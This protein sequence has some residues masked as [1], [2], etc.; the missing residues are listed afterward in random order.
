MIKKFKFP[1]IH[2]GL[3]LLFSILSYLSES[4]AQNIDTPVFG[5]KSHLP[6]QTGKWVT[7]S[8]DNIIY[9]SEQ[10]LL[11]LS[12]DDLSVSFLSKINGL[13][14]SQ[15]DLIEYDQYNNQ[16]VII[17]NNS[18]IDLVTENEIYNIPDIKDNSNIIGS[19][20]IN[21][22]AI[23]NPEIM[24]I[25]T[26]FGMVEYR[27]KL[28]E[29]GSTIFTNLPIN[30][31]ANIGTKIYAATDDGLYYIDESLNP[32]IAD[33][34][35]WQLLGES[36]GLPILYEAK[37]I[38]NFDDQ[39]FFTDG[40]YIYF[41]M[42]N[43][44]F[45]LLYNEQNASYN[46]T[47]LSSG[48]KYLMAGLRA[49]QDSRILYWENNQRFEGSSSCIDRL[50][51]SIEDEK[52]QIWFADN[53][54]GFRY[55]EHP[56]GGCQRLSFNS[57]LTENG[58]N[59]AIHDG[60]VAVASGGVT[61]NFGDLF[62]RDGIYLLSDNDWL[63][64]NESFYKPM[65][66]NDFLNQYKVDF[67]P[68]GD[69]L[70][71]G[72]FWNG[73]MEYN[74]GDQSAVVYNQNNS[75][76]QGA[77]G[78]G[79]A[80]ISDMQFDEGGNLWITNFNAPRPLVVKDSD[81]NWQ[82]FATNSDRRVGDLTIDDFNNI[83]ITTFGTSGGLFVFNPGQDLSSAGDD[84]RRSINLNNS[85]ISS[86]IIYTVAADLDGSVWV[87]TAEGVVLFECG[88]NV[89]N[90]NECRGLRP[91]VVVDSIVAFL[92]ETEE[93]RCIAFDGADRKWFGTRNGI[94]VQ[95]PSGDEEVA[96]FTTDNSPLFDNEI[97][98]MAFDPKNGFMYISSNKGLQ[99]IRTETTEGGT[100][101]QNSVYAFPNPVTPD[102][103]GPIA[104]KGL[105]KDAIV[106]ITNLNGKLVYETQA[107]GGQAIW[108]G[109]SLEGQK[110]ETGVYLVFSTGTASFNQPD[111][112][113]TKIL[114]ISD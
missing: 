43:N 88:G 21:D 18:N 79:R 5:W 103:S 48:Q 13:S 36:N 58:S 8:S 53:F 93:V 110:V 14:D 1:K 23:L 40:K 59:I 6:Y 92:L 86:S 26:A 52:G 49:P 27:L 113:V 85:E 74:L 22:V 9:A 95:S 54:R 41:S 10:S 71:I 7:Q 17:Y 82:S 11:F 56:L 19:R 66:D 32:N 44:D 24:L 84:Q 64:I 73:I 94:F 67:S 30:E 33:F 20:K 3:F 89:F 31:V 77:I 16:L 28:R 47:Y 107:L 87:G 101:H 108:D 46:I 96:R 112:Y 57:P 68:S 65:Q 50:L 114:F 97:V 100:R 90:A 111:S 42:G 105:A 81:G 34:N 109:R 61:D 80:R 72:S 29:F 12:K 78:D 25:S 63:N 106:K 76:L 35:R 83:W 70:M 102:Y 104:I 60:K 91:K 15:I 4:G 75:A 38:V 99:S 45:S 37:S 62:S 2:K 55:T 69:K 51:Y 39:I 98:D